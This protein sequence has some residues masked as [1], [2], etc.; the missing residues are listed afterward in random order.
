MRDDLPDLL[1]PL[2]Y[3]ASNPRSDS[4]VGFVRWQ[5][6]VI[7]A[8]RRLAD[9]PDDAFIAECL[10]GRL[11][12]LA[13]L[14]ERCPEAQAI[15]LDAIESRGLLT[16]AIVKALAIYPDRPASWLNGDV[17]LTP[18]DG[19]D[20]NLVA[21]AIIATIGGDGHRE[22]II[23]CLPIWAAV[24]AGTLRTS[25]E[26]IDI[27][28]PYPYD[29]ASR[30]QADSVVRAL[31]GASKGADVARSP[32]AYDA[33]LA[34]A[35]TFWNVHSMT[36]PCI[37]EREV[38]PRE[39]SDAGMDVAQDPSAASAASDGVGG[40]SDVTEPNATATSHA[41]AVHA[42]AESDHV[43]AHTL[44][45]FTPDEPAEVNW[46][47]EAVE[48]DGVPPKDMR[49]RA[50]DL[51][52]SFAEAVES[53]RPHNLYDPDKREVNVGLVCRAAREVITAL[54]APDLWCSEH[55]SHVGRA[56]VETHITLAWMAKQNDPT[57]YR[58]YKDYG[59]GK[60]KLN[61]LIA[62]EVPAEWLIDGAV[63]AIANIRKTSHN[64][65]ILDYVAVDTRATFSGM[66]L[67]EMANEAGLLDL[68][69]HTYQLQSGI[70]HSEWW[71]VELHAMERCFNILH[72]GHL[73]PSFDLSRGSNIDI[74]RSWLIALYGVIDLSMQ[75]LGVRKQTVDDAFGWLHTPA[76]EDESRE[77]GTGR[78]AGPEE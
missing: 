12:G 53:S 32:D 55:G 58:R 37:R 61:A 73:I 45:T 25:Q 33:A 13:R 59:A 57:I 36:S 62:E 1:W 72:R 74:A 39:A 66:S 67:R 17:P 9:P 52:L 77:T 24:N 54:G 75:I 50:M 63:E 23:K 5:E 8:L 68:Y 76:T 56:I 2:L 65:D 42:A 70:A 10:S 27:L 78:R 43:A 7:G 15:V 71:T 38:D 21:D 22:A 19:D 14:V 51:T 44:H 41:G 60:A 3:L 6:D 40:S 48:T 34:W 35:R 20:L 11:T 18:P 69:R 64:D 31:W 28:Q 46:L 47:A 26:T 49:R 29:L 30:S 16:P 4:F